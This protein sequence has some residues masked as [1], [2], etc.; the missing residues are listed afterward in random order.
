[1]LLSSPHGKE[2]S[3]SLFLEAEK[4]ALISRLISFD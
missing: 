3:F 2:I 1:M 4:M